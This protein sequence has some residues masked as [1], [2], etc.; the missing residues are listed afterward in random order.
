MKLDSTCSKLKTLLRR[1][2]A[3]TREALQEAIETAL[4]LITAQDAL[5]WFTHCGYPIAPKDA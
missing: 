3:R 1:R 5:G 2:G 4:T